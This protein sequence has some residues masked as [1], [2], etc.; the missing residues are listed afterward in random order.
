MRA[1]KRKVIIRKKFDK[2][3]LHKEVNLN[4][5]SASCPVMNLKR[6]TYNEL[7]LKANQMSNYLLQNK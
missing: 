7:Y 1:A 2:E 6:N 4:A 3:A 5:V